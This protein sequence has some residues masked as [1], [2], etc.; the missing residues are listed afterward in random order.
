MDRLFEKSLTMEMYLLE[1]TSDVF[2]LYQAHLRDEVLHGGHQGLAE[3]LIQLE[4]MD[5]VNRKDWEKRLW[6]EIQELR[7][8]QEDIKALQ[9]HLDEKDNELVIPEFIIDPQIRAEAL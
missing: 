7:L 6:S 1:Q 4:V 2:R 9:L 3:Y 8:I 5:D